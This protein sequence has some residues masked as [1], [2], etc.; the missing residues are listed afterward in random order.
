MKPRPWLLLWSCDLSLSDGGGCAV[1]GQVLE[2]VGSLGRLGGVGEY[3]QS[4][5]P[6]RASSRG[7]EV[8]ETERTKPA[9]T[10]FMV[11]SQKAA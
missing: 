4:Q 1:F 11:L 9:R 6:V 10:R 5:I 8:C 3:G 7:S 2:V